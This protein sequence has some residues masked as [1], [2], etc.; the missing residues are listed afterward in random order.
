MAKISTLGGP[1]DE[2]ARADEPQETYLV[3]DGDDTVTNATQDSPSL[4]RNSR[5]LT[6]EERAELESYNEE[7]SESS[8]GMTDSPSSK[9]QSNS[10][11]KSAPES[12]RLAPDAENRLGSAG[13]SGK[14]SA[15]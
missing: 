10:E 14:P 6:D 9:R 15:R 4:V 12:P 11:S 1:S 2:G 7:V 5:L 8:D 3:D 13:K